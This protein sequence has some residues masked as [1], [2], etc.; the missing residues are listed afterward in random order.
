MVSKSKSKTKAPS[1]FSA[2]AVAA[3]V[4]QHQQQAAADAFLFSAFDNAPQAADYFAAIS[5]TVESQR[6]RVYDTHTSTVALDISL[7]QPNANKTDSVSLGTSSTC[8]KWGKL[9]NS[10]TQTAPESAS[11]KKKKR[12]KGD[13]DAAESSQSSLVIAVGFANGEVQLMSIAHGGVFRTLVGG[14]TAPV[15]DFAFFPD[16]IRGLSVAEDGDVIEWDLRTGKELSKMK[17]GSKAVRRI[18]INHDGSLLLTAD[19]QIK[20]WSWQGKTLIKTF[21]GHATQITACLFSADSRYCITIAEQDRYISVWDCSPDSVAINVAKSGDV[22]IWQHYVENK[23][24]T[25][26]ATAAP[27]KKSKKK[28]GVVTPMAPTGFLR[29]TS[30]ASVSKESIP[31]LAATFAESRIVFG[32]GS[33]L[34]PTFEHLTYTDESGDVLA[35]LSLTRT[36]ATSMLVD[37]SS[38]AV[39]AMKAT[40]KSYDEG[41]AMVTGNTGTQPTPMTPENHMA[42]AESDD[43]VE[44]ENGTSKEPT[45]ED[46]LKSMTILSAT[47]NASGRSAASSNQAKPD[48]MLPPTAGTLHTMLSQAIKSGDKQL[49]ERC[50]GV[51]NP[52]IILATARR[53]P[54]TQAPLLLEQLLI[55]LQ[56]RPNRAA[57]LIEWM[58]AVVMVHS[59]YLMTVPGLV[60]Q[61]GTLYQTLESRVSTFQKLLRISGRLDLVTSQIALRQGAGADAEEQVQEDSK[62]E[63]E[64]VV[65]YNEE[66]D[67]LDYEE[68][69]MEEVDGS[70]MDD[71]EEEGDFEEDFDESDDGEDDFDDLEEDDEEDEEEESDE[72]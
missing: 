67:D 69:V 4:I 18:K 46:R 16:G 42:A 60:K 11:K 36:P 10:T 17:I 45:I 66:E 53:L 38:L 64:A 65:V 14:H 58:R 47:N 57:A 30:S 6:L 13:D 55:R 39:Q 23:G 12:R 54:A 2:K 31:I 8:L 28:S 20:L 15:T 68:D 49:L 52:K 43:E 50:L 72:E 41:K 5:Q 7:N 26:A 21:T 22:A 29:V 33:P 3:A 9:A 48:S 40:K 19:H 44:N 25:D 51:R 27:G 1:A 59:T 61:L 24:N 71:N 35:D 70:D 62:D 63:T 37:K 34:K 56:T 32:R